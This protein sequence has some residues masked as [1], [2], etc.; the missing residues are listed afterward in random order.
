MKVDKEKLKEKLL[1][2]VTNLLNDHDDDGKNDDRQNKR[3]KNTDE[4]DDE[5]VG[6]VVPRACACVAR[7]TC[8]FV[9][10]R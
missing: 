5:D 2:W 10:C 1:W 7:G 3:T 8:W 6:V 9:G 4:N